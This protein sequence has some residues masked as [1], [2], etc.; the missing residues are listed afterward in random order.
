LKTLKGGT[1]TGAALS[2]ASFRFNV[3]SFL[4]P[5]DFARQAVGENAK[6]FNG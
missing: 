4:T 3:S 2:L 5:K 1:G 6:S